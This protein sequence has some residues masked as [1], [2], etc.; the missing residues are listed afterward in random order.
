MHASLKALLP[1]SL[2]KIKIERL[3]PFSIFIALRLLC[4]LEEDN[5]LYMFFGLVTYFL[6]LKNL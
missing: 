5:F 3:S 4:L 2:S 6:L 1:D